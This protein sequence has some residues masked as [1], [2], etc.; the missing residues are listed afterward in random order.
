[1]ADGSDQVAMPARLDPQHAKAV[2]GIVERDPLYKTG[3][4]FLVIGFLLRH[5]SEALIEAASLPA[6][7]VSRDAAGE[8]ARVLHGKR[9]N[10]SSTTAD[11]GEQTLFR[12]PPVSGN[13]ASAP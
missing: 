3:Q 8:S 4:D 1:M 7:T 13:S 9:W 6:S 11:R 10:W 5:E 2:L 12:S